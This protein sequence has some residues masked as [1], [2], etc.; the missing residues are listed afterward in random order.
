[1]VT[2]RVEGWAV[3]MRGGLEVVGVKGWVKGQVQG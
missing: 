2:G 1:M 3:M